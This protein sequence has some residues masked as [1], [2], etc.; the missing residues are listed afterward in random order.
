MYDFL[1]NRFS[2]FKHRDFRLFFFAQSV[3]LI[4][5]LAHEMARSWIIVDMMGR[6]TDLG[7]LNLALAVPSLLLMPYGGFLVDRINVRSLMISTKALLALLSLGIAYVVE[8]NQ[9]QMWMLVGFAITEGFVNAFDSPSFQKLVVRLVPRADYQQAMALNST[10]FHTARA[11]GPFAAGFLMQFH[12][13]SL[14]FFADAV[15]F[16]GVIVALKMIKLRAQPAEPI[17]ESM[18]T[19]FFSGFKYLLKDP[20]I[21]YRLLQLYLAIGIVFPLILVVFRTFIQKKF[22][23]DSHDFAYVFMFPA[24]GSFLGAL[25]FT[26]LKPKNPLRVLKFSIPLATVMLIAV[27]Q[28]TELAFTTLFMSLSGYS[29]YLSFASLTVSLQLEVKESLRGRLSSMIAM[30]FVGFGPLMGYP[31]GIFADH[32]GFEFSVQV[33]AGI[34]LIGSLLLAIFHHDIKP[35]T[36]KK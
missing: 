32:V 20:I 24:I 19:G 36:A 23:L 8:F 28:S 2:P 10:N 21:R 6:A 7:T 29:M 13:P 22:A 3:S 33:L 17:D 15:S 18:P 25:T 31:I 16:I 30:G 11:L 35:K 1:K 27:T 14:V 26:F 12:G 9:I 34:F 4:G 5:V